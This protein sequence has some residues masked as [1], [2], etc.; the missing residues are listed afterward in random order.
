[1]LEE[2]RKQYLEFECTTNCLHNSSCCKVPTEVIRI[3]EY[4]SIDILI[5]GQGAGKDEERLRRPFVGRAGKYMRNIIKYLWDNEFCGK[6]NLALS[7]NVRF[8]PTNLEGKDREPTR[9]EISKCF[10]HLIQDISLIDPKVIVPVGKNAA[11]SILEWDT[12][13]M[14]KI[15]GKTYNRLVNGKDRVIVPTWHPS[16]LVRNY[17]SFNT[18]QN[19]KLDTEF[20]T[21]ILVALQR[22]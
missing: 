10:G 5:F 20:I 16:Y 14:S 9:N 12:A 13:I 1:M 2:L 7:N 22:L 15:R 11:C 17:G 21:D 4:D 19:R 6:F 18:S 3:T 8:H